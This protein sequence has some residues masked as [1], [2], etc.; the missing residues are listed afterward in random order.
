[1]KYSI[2]NGSIGR[3]SRKNPKMH[4]SND[5]FIQ[6]SNIFNKNLMQI[7][8]LLYKF[9]FIEIPNK[10]RPLSSNSVLTIKRIETFTTF[11]SN[12]TL[13]TGPAKS[14]QMMHTLMPKKNRQ[15]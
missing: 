9:T 10:L 12:Q 11:K 4:N 6:F 5:T 14:K 1:M 8:K 7:T 15:K 13:L 2:V 3:I